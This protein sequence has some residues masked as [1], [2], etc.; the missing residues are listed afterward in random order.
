MSS[1]PSVYQKLE[2]ARQE[3][4]DLG[5]RNSLLNYRLLKA[6]GLE[7]VDGSPQDVFE[8]LVRNKKSV[9]FLPKRE[10]ENELLL[11][12]TESNVNEKEMLSSQEDLLPSQQRVPEPKLNTNLTEKQLQARLLNTYYTAQTF[13]EEQGV[14]ILYMALGMLRWYESESSKEVRKAP[15]ILIPVKLERINAR[16]RFRVSSTEEDIGFNLSLITKAK[17]EFGIS[18]PTL[19][20]EEEIDV[21]QYFLQVEE[22]IQSEPRW[23]VDR[24]AIVLGF[25]SFGKFLMYRDLDVTNWPEEWKPTEHDILLSLLNDGFSEPVSAIQDDDFMDPHVSFHDM[26]HVMDADSSQLQAILDVNSGR[27]LVIQGPPGTGKSQTI[28]NIIA[29]AVAR[30]KTV[31]FVSEK[32]AALEVVKRRLDHVGLGDACLELHSHKTNKKTFLNE[33]ARTLELRKPK[34]KDFD[35]EVQVLENFRRRLN[36]YCVGIHTPVGESGL[37]P[38]QLLGELVRFRHKFGDDFIFPSLEIDGMVKWDRSTFQH[39][40]LLVEELQK[41]LGALGNPK[42]H[43]FWGSGRTVFLPTEVGKLRETVTKT[44]QAF[45]TLKESSRV[46]AQI[47]RTETIQDVKDVEMVGVVAS[48]ILEA[49]D[50]QG[51]RIDAD[52]WT[53]QVDE[54]Q[55]L[56]SSGLKFSSLQ[57]RYRDILIPEAWDQDLLDI[58]QTLMTYHKKW[59]RWLSGS[60]RKAKKKLFR[61]YKDS[62][63]KKLDDLQVVE[64]IM[65]TQRHQQFIQS[66][67]AVGSS[68]FGVHWKKEQSDWVRFNEWVQWLFPFYKEIQSGHIPGW[69]IP[70]LT[71]PL[72][73][74]KLENSIVTVGQQ[75]EQFRECGAEL[76]N[77]LELNTSVKFGNCQSL[78]DQAFQEL[79]EQFKSWVDHADSIQTLVSYNLLCD[80]CNKEKLEAIVSL[81]RTWEHASQRL[82]DLFRFTWYDAL[83]KQAF[84]ERSVLAQF[85]GDRHRHVVETFQELDRA[86]LE[87][88]KMK[89]V[90]IHWKKIPQYDAGGQLGVLKREFEKKRGHLPIRRL[91]ENAG[92]AIQALKPVFMMGPLSIA[93]YH[94]QE[95]VKFDLVIFDEASQVKPVDAFGAILRGKQVVVVGDSKQMPPTHFFDSLTKGEESEEDNTVGDME[96]ILGLFLAQNAPRRMLRWHY[97]SRHESLIAVSNLEFYDNR[98]VVFPSPDLKKD[99]SGLVFHYLPHGRYDRGRNRTNAEEARAVAQAVME[100]AKRY[101]HLSLGVAAFSVAQMQAIQDQ[102]ELLRQ[103]DPSCESFFQA[104]PHEPF[105]VKNLENVQGDERDVMFISIGYGKTEDGYL[106]MDFGALNRDGGERRLNV[107]ITRARFRCEVFANMTDYDIDLSRTQAQGMKALKTFLRYARTGILEIPKDTDREADSPFEEVVAE[108]IRSMG[109]EV[110]K[111]VGSG[112]FYIDLAVVDPESPGRYVLGVE[113]DGATYHSARSARDRDRLRQQ[114]LEGLGW[115]IHRIWSTDWFRHPDR[116]QKRLA[117]AIEKVRLQIKSSILVEV[118]EEITNVFS[119]ER[120]D[121]I[122]R[123]EQK[124]VTPYQCASLNI[125]MF[126]FEFHKLP[127]QQI[128]LWVLEVVKVESPVHIHEVIKRI[129][130]AAGIKRAGNRIQEAVEKACRALARLGKVEIKGDFLWLEGMKRPDIRDRSH[131]PASSKKLDLVSTEEIW[132]AIERVVS[133][134]LGIKEDDIT[135]AVCRL[136]GFMRVTEEMKDRIEKIISKMIA[137]NVLEKQGS[138]CI[139][140]NEI[141]L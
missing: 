11:S 9:T 48:K 21:A 102:L 29:E 136:L 138:H 128:A 14:N 134:A 58:R 81:S 96:S 19:P 64:D 90:E 6:R 8:I 37:T 61:L 33:L 56:V 97:R 109:Y 123:E 42:E 24:Q 88:N 108:T 17:A 110:R 104:H 12:E 53:Q 129:C 62:S 16:E 95:S 105:F 135:P 71:A 74:T 4:L 72:N 140:T 137:E 66:M 13:I 51:V 76:E 57:H 41:L 59:L 44:K 54:I 114:V 94:P 43:P 69:I 131:L 112:G 78:S 30:G 118:R 5:L 47:M 1:N 34:V 127:T 10:N 141:S 49:P 99:R 52:E 130:E 77:L 68:C 80:T 83:I 120:E 115:Y 45:E 55:H 126:G 86:L 46:L 82:T 117:E 73:R 60:Y 15:L 103:E 67:D 93:T 139:L 124:S 28:T 2:K 63:G 133:V 75:L 98:L 36:D 38:Y 92:Y 84:Q 100:H 122:A 111:Q 89:L 31:L 70:L 121:S 132:V 87:Y 119:L 91:M 39:R 65:E 20:E 85:D 25:F 35:E 50:L 113:C 106:S 22:A 40:I 101:P 32:M 116:E 27:N 79:N 107:L 18:I 23:S 26:H 3:L 125:D 7:V